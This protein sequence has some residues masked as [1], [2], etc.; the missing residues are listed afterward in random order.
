MAN[1]PDDGKR[2]SQVAPYLDAII[3]GA[4]RA[5]DAITEHSRRTLHEG[6][7]YEEDVLYAR[8][9]QSLP[10]GDGPLLQ[11]LLA[12]WQGLSGGVEPRFLICRALLQSD[13]EAFADGLTSLLEEALGEV[14][15]RQRSGSGDPDA[16][17]STDRLSLE[18]LALGK[19]ATALGIPH[20]ITHVLLPHE[21]LM[22]PR[23]RLPGPDDWRT[24]ENHRS[25]G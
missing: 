23:R 11:D 7:E 16:A 9:L 14:R 6:V 1:H 25:L 22:P 4:G 13:A 12:R 24:I 19:I 17:V 18:G 8:F 20:R 21:L 5:S 15:A 3:A 10:A 2:T